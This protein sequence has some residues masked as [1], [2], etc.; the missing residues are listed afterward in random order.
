MS[1]FICGMYLR[2]YIYILYDGMY[3]YANVRLDYLAALA[4]FRAKKRSTA[5]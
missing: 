5:S 2:I 1:W 3:L 4:S